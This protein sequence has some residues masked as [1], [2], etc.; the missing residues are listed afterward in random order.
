MSELVFLNGRMVSGDE[1]RVSVFDAGFSHGAGLFE[2]LRTYHGRPM[3]LTEH[4]ERLYRSAAALEIAVRLDIAQVQTAVEE[5][6][7]ANEL[8][9]ARIRITVTPGPVPRPVQSPGEETM[10]TVLI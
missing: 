10:P 5:L 2:T 9:D 4:I 7:A 1:A 6:L 3:G 8:L